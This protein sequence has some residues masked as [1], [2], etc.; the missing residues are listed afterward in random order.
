MKLIKSTFMA[1][2]ISLMVMGSAKLSEAAGKYPSISERFKPVARQVVADF[3]KQKDPLGELPGGTIAWGVSY[4]MDAFLTMYQATGDEDYL[5]YF[6]KLADAV[7]AARADVRGDKDWKG[8]IRKGWLTGGV[9]TLGQPVILDGENGKPSLEIRTTNNSG[10][11]KTTIEIIPAA[12]KKTFSIIATNTFRTAAPKVD[13]FDHLTMEDL[14]ARVN[15][16]PYKVTLIR[17]KRLGDTIPRAYKPFTPPTENVVLHGH[18]TGKII[19][20]LAR[21]AAMVKDNA[22]L[23][24]YASRAQKYLQC[25]EEA[26]AD[27]NGDWREKDDYGYYIF[28]KGIP[29]WSDGAPEPFNTLSATG[30]ALLYLYDATG[31]EEY[32][33]KATKLARLVQ[34]EFHLQDDGT[35]NFY[36][37]WGE[38]RQGWKAEDHVSTNTIAYPGQK[39]VEDLSH[40]QLTLRFMLEAH[41]RGIV[42]TDQ[43]LQRWSKTFWKH[44]YRKDASGKPSLSNRVDGNPPNTEI[45]NYA[46]YGFADF[47]KADPALVDACR[48]IYETQFT[49]IN[50][51]AV[52]LAGWAELAK[53][54]K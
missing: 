9:Y 40:L 29:F 45:Y 41:Q 2:G 33:D 7:V 3:Q 14:E 23:S 43:D 39:V 42:F 5:R 10:N 44:I 19:T 53:S 15:P 50:S 32:R 30:T 31:K 22:A 17:V 48:E 37:W 8:Q 49:P 21:F 12:D 25:S 51:R 26:I 27:M 38:M 54:D 35:Y 11:D 16:N 47:G 20:P 36:Y 6:E 4:D 52:S 1:I 13:R 46:I 18:H 28:E 34:S 24:Q